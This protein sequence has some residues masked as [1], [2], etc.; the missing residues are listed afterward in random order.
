MTTT[1]TSIGRYDHGPAMVNIYNEIFFISS[2]PVVDQSF[3]QLMLHLESHHAD[4]AKVRVR[5]IGYRYG[6][7]SSHI[8]FNLVTT[9][10]ICLSVIMIVF[11]KI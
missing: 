4:M 11:I 5:Q 1:S 10:F 7:L 6:T 9:N 3:L 2:S 8:I